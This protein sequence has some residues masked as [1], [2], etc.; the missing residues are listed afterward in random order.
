M[1][2]RRSS[3]R[4]EARAR[5]GERPTQCARLPA[6]RLVAAGRRRRQTNIEL[7]AHCVNKAAV[8]IDR[9]RSKKLHLNEG[10]R[11]TSSLD[12]D[13]DEL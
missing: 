12:Q 1:F 6:G 3:D 2:M 13:D 8:V 10:A 7:E 4:D 5:L 9:R 11:A